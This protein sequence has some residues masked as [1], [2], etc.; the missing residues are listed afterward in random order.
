MPKPGE[1]FI[2]TASKKLN[3]YTYL[4]G[5]EWRR[6]PYFSMVINESHRDMSMCL[7]ETATQAESKSTPLYL[8]LGS[9]A[10]IALFNSGLHEM[11]KCPYLAAIDKLIKSEIVPKCASD[12]T[13]DSA[14]IVR[15]HC[16]DFVIHF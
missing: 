11:S 8:S 4:S 15:R 3:C 12:C 9:V 14:N 10:T 5:K 13:A 1:K 16:M 6:F 2:S 7:L